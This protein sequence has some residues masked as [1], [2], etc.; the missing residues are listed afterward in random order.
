MAYL[1]YGIRKSEK[2]IARIEY[3]L[4]GSVNLRRRSLATLGMTVH[5]GT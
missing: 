2:E 1:P 3:L 4:L 5:F